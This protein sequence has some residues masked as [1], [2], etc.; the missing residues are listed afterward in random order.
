MD[1]INMSR[2]NLSPIRE[3]FG[4]NEEGFR[5][6]LVSLEEQLKDFVD[7]V[8]ALIDADD[9]SKIRGYLHNLKGVSD[10]L[11]LP[12]FPDLSAEIAKAL[13]DGLDGDI[14]E[15]SQSL[16]NSLSG[17]IKELHHTLKD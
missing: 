12:D 16:L 14:T 3:I 2:L 10:Y 15:L 11:S 13:S 5:Q 4:D 7:Q 8:P 9:M 1:K 6:V 17:T